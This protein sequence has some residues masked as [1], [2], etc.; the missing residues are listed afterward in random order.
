MKLL[1]LYKQFGIIGICKRGIN[2][3]INPFF[4]LTEIIVVAI[5]NHKKNDTFTNNS[6]K[7]MTKKRVAE[8]HRNNYIN[9]SEAKKFN[10]FL[11]S[12]CTGYYVEIKNELAAWGFVQ[13][14]GKYQYGEYIYDIPNKVYILKNLFVKSKFRSKSLGKLINEARI[15]GVPNNCIPC[16]FVLPDNHYAMRNLK[17]YGFQEY[18][19]VSH[20]IC[21][22]IN[23]K[24]RFQ[25][26]K[27][28]KL[29]KHIIKGF[30]K[31]Y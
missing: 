20:S 30:K 6:V 23:M 16:G 25:I 8:W 5:P 4:K 10:N 19:K 9:D 17:L 29:N 2:H 12:F 1:D 7:L 3:L 21:F 22:N 13:N 18:F 15:M 11:D 14:K 24:I 26:I 28:N 31:L 27:D